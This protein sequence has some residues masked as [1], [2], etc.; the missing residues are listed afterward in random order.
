MKYLIAF[1]LLF[2]TASYAAKRDSGQPKNVESIT[3]LA[4]SSIAIPATEISKLYSRTEN[5]DV[6]AVFDSTAELYSKIED[7]DPADII[8][9]PSIKLLEQLKE[10]G[11][12]DSTSKIILAGNR[13]AVISTKDMKYSTDKLDVKEIL[14]EIY[15]K[16]IM[17]IGDTNTTSLGFFTKQALQSLNLWQKFERRV[18]LGPTSSKT[19][20]LIIKG[21]SAGIV[22][23]SDAELYKDD[24]N[25]LAVIPDTMHEPIEYYAAIVVGDNMEKARKYLA[26]LSSNE[27]KQ[28]FKMNGFIV[29]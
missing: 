1:L 19:T 29:K 15:N 28:V 13:L 9:T 2:S 11:L 16:T 25:L 20:D 22:Y 3:V 24:L 8:I 17:T 10:H 4:S 21:Q 7:G 18:Q 23:L 26:Y 6:N 14:G 12:I 5:V 27:A